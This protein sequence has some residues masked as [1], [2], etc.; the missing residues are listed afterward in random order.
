MQLGQSPLQSSVVRPALLPYV[1]IG[2]GVHSVEFAEEYV[3]G[4]QRTHRVIPA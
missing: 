3:P 4:L 1:P 2:H